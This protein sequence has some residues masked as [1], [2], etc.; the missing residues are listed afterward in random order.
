MISIASLNPPQ[1]KAVETVQGPVLILAG[2]GSGKTRTITYRIAHLVKN[3]N[4]PPEKILGVSFTNKATKEMQERVK[5]LIGNEAL[6]KMTLSTFHSLGVKILKKEIHHLGM[7]NNFNI[8]TQSDQISLIRQA[9]K[10]YKAQKNFDQKRILSKISFLKNKGIGNQEFP[11]SIYMDYED[12][13]DLACESVYNFYQEK[14]FFFNSIDF[15]DI[16]FLTVKLFEKY[17]EIANKYSKLFSFIMVDEYQD[18]NPLQFKIIKALTSMHNNICV[19]GDDDQ[20]IYGFRGAEISNILNFEKTYANSVVIKL[21]ENYRSTGPI[22]KLANEVIKANL[23]RN[24]KNLWTSRESTLKPVLWAMGDADHEAEIVAEDILN[25][26]NNGGKFSDMA[27]L[28]RGNNQASV[29]E[30]TLRMNGIPY[31]YLGGQKFYEKKEVM[32]LLAYLKVILNPNDEVALRRILNVPNR[33][34]GLTT[35]SK[36]LK[37]AEEEKTSLYTALDRQP[38]LD[39]VREKNIQSFTD[40][41]RTFKGEFSSLPLH[42]AL[43]KLID[44]LHFNDFIAKE[45]SENPKQMER[46][47]NDVESFIGG[48][49]RFLKHKPNAT[50]ATFIDDMVLRDVE[51]DD[52]KTGDQVTIMTIHSSKG[53]EFHTVYLLGVEEEIL[54]HKKSII[55]DEDIGEER[56]LLYVGITRAKEK[57]V[58]TY[59]KEREFYG[60]KLPR[61]KSRFVSGPHLASLFDEADR[62]NF[63]HLKKEEI[64]D[65]K[66]SFFA[67]LLSEL[68]RS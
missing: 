53:L 62:T 36:Y 57:L 42:V 39:P 41:I 27:I 3:L 31:G 15:D 29:I 66:K 20:S 16:L 6:K 30:D 45:Y 35:L 33:G 11:N 52:E 55:G 58:M 50:L 14:L 7:Q 17:P 28:F 23:K 1:R 68:D 13:Y 38:G 61:N 48:C 18:T 51:E 43:R 24:D 26:K 46:R 67:N 5:E 2:A 44:Q 59:C 4:I 21:E 34:I 12:P 63:G 49:E 40:L 54:P 32:D 47:K 60:K 10:H 9:L 19:V 8:Y 25:N 65:Y 22:L 37:K 64:E 56:R